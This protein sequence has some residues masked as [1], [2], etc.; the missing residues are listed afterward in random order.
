MKNKSQLFAVYATLGILVMSILLSGCSRPQE[1]A[2]ASSSNSAN[3]DSAG[4]PK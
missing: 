2:P 1:P 4:N 3:T